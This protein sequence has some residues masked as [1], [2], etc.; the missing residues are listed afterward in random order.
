VQPTHGL[1]VES[2]HSIFENP[3]N[4]A[5]ELQVDRE[6]LTNRS[7]L[8]LFHKT[9]SFKAEDFFLIFN[10]LLGSRLWQFAENSLP[11]DKSVGGSGIHAAQD[12]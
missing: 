3:A 7:V 12:R 10:Y 6:N 11:T 5:S 2:V 9:D 1:N 4:V 8:F